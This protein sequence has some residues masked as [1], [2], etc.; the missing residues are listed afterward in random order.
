MN[1]NQPFLNAL[2]DEMAAFGVPIEGLH[3][4]TGPGVFEA[5]ILYSDPLEA[6]DRAVLF[7]TGA[8]EIGHR[9]GIMPTFM[10]KWNADLPGCSGH[11]H[12][13]LWDRRQ[14]GTC[15]TTTAPPA[16]DEPAVRELPGR[17]AGLPARAAAVLRAHGEQLQA[18][19]RGRLGA[20]P[21]QLGHRQPH[22]RAAGDPGQR[23]SR[24]ASRPGST[25]PTSTPTW[26][27]PPR[28]PAAFTA[29]SKAEAAARA[30]HGQRLRRQPGRPAA[31]QPGRGHRALEES[32]IARELFG[33]GV[34]RAL[35]RQPPWE[36]RQFSQAVT[37]WELA[38]YFEII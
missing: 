2:F 13:S 33:D 24:R 7:K 19:G 22:H 11:I 10:A 3:T 8:K 20:D 34:R 6:A 28:W 25:A 27:W 38:R 36:W 12:Q 17:A 26:R 21:G 31:P 32:S 23:R 35:R 4:E 18:P 1:Q 30:G 15:S 37:N 29:S 5:A 9:F 14:D 16:Q